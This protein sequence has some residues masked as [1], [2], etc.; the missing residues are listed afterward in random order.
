MRLYKRLVWHLKRIIETI[1]NASPEE[2][3]KI[4]NDVVCQEKRHEDEDKKSVTKT[5]E[6]DLWE[7]YEAILK[8]W[9][10][11]G[12]GDAQDEEALEVAPEIVLMSHDRSQECMY[13]PSIEKYYVDGDKEDESYV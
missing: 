7:E 13:S 9:K 3:L 10:S 6:L 11:N 4:D 1:R 8:E 5:H 2:A 12:G